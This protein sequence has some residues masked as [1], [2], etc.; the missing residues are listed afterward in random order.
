MERQAVVR[1]GGI[2]VVLTAR[3]RPFHNL[4]DF[5]VLGLDPR[6]VRLL[7]VKSGYL[8][9]EL[10][11]LANPNLMALSDG[12]VNQDVARLPVKCIRRPIFPWDTAFAWQP[13]VLVSARAK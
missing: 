2:T 4:A 10:A 11:P 7:V 1:I 9:P 13:A 12:V 5:D 8:S 3:R 6:A